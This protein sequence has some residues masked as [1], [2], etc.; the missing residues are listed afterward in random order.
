[1]TLR[2][3]TTSEVAN[4]M[5][6]EKARIQRDNGGGAKVNGMLTDEDDEDFVKV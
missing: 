6:A 3:P 4:R 5:E 2:L 1:M